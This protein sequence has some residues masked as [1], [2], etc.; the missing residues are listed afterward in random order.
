MMSLT[1]IAKVIRL[2]SNYN[3]G[4]NNDKEDGSI[5]QRGNIILY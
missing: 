3:Q 1:T 4:D 2:K 5:K